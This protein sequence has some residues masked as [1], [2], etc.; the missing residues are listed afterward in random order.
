MSEPCKPGLCTGQYGASSNS[1]VMFLFFSGWSSTHSHTACRWSCGYVKNTYSSWLAGR[2]PA[3]E[4][5]WL[6]PLFSTGLL[7]PFSLIFFQPFQEG[8]FFPLFFGSHF[9][10]ETFL[11]LFFFVG[12]F[13]DIAVMIKPA[14]NCRACTNLVPVKASMG[15]PGISVTVDRLLVSNISPTPVNF[16]GETWGI[17]RRQSTTATTPIPP[18]IGFWNYPVTAT[19]AWISWQH[20]KKAMSV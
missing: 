9:L 7:H 19:W 8:Q 5:P 2:I 17:F 3:V 4:A 16:H 12:D 10:I 20:E 18:R 1:Q 15:Q 11:R 6:F 14:K 13:R